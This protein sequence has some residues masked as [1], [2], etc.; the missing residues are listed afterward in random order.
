MS[1]D[2]YR[3]IAGCLGAGLAVGSIAKWLDLLVE[4]FR[5]P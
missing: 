3:W 4:T 2:E 1:G 5:R